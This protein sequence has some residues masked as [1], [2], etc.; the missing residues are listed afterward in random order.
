MQ[1]ATDYRFTIKTKENKTHFSD[2]LKEVRPPQLMNNYPGHVQGWVGEDL[3]QTDGY[4][5]AR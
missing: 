4:K 1:L 2:L 3:H 5:A